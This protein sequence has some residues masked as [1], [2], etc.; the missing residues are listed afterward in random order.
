MHLNHS[1]FLKL[2]LIFAWILFQIQSDASKTTKLHS[3]GNKLGLV[4]KPQSI[5]GGL[6]LRA[7][8]KSGGAAS[9]LTGTVLLKAGGWDSAQLEVPAMPGL[10]V[11]TAQAMA[12]LSGMLLL[13]HSL[14][15]TVSSRA[16][17][18]ST[19]LKSAINVWM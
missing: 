14:H 7:P 6:K 17:K 15:P 16:R 3:L 11:T 4:S 12:R 5:F 9:C 1:V 2:E 10:L 8:P 19:N 13:W 18:T